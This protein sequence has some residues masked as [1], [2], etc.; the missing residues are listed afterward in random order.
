MEVELTRGR[1]FEIRPL[2]P[3][4]AWA[5]ARELDQQETRYPIEVEPGFGSA[6]DGRRPQVG[7]GLPT[8][9]GPPLHGVPHV[10]VL[11]MD[12]VVVVLP[13]DQA[14]VHQHRRIDQ[15]AEL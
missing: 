15:V 4:E 8:A 6:P 2:P 14:L 11:G 12:G 1:P 9:E 3:E 13:S 7:A 5:L 10:L